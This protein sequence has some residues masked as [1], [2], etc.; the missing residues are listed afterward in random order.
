M[1]LP[2]DAELQSELAA[3]TAPIPHQR[4]RRQE[5][6]PKGGRVFLA[7][8]LLIAAGIT[9]LV[10]F[11]FQGAAVYSMTVDGLMTAKDKHVGR[12]VRVEGELLPGSLAKRERPCEFR[13]KLRG[14]EQQLPVRYGQCVI[15]DTLR[16][17]PQG[18]VQVTVEGTLLASGDFEATLVMAKCASKYD[19]TTHTM[20]D[21][22]KG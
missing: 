22:P 10:L 19:P 15:P 7:V 18:G 9:G 8:V 1:T 14:T 6:A 5:P 2:L 3:T 16:D 11:G 4:R 17:T 13:M 20:R 12:R 21:E